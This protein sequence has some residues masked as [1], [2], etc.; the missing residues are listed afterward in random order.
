MESGFITLSPCRCGTALS[1]PLPKPVKMT[2]LVKDLG[3]EVWEYNHQVGMSS[4]K[5]CPTNIIYP[6]LVWGSGKAMD[7]SRHPQL[8][9]LPTMDTWKHGFFPK[10]NVHAQAYLVQIWYVSRIV[11]MCQGITYPKVGDANQ[12]ARNHPNWPQVPSKIHPFQNI[13][14]LIRIAYCW[15]FMV[16]SNS[17]FHSK[18]ISGTDSLEVLTIYKA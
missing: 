15:R 2:Y 18:A 5:T 10:R 12:Y 9:D 6:L 4:T 7:L 14:P 11:K 13:V 17:T 8:P 1:I 16:V 3:A